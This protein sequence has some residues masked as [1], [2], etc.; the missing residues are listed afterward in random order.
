MTSLAGITVLITRSAHQ[1]G[2]LRKELELR[3]AH[4]LELPVIAICPPNSWQA[5]D[6]ALGAIA[7]YDW[8]IFSSTN[9]ATIVVERATTIGADLHELKARKTASIGRST[10]DR[11]VELG[12][13]IDFQPTDFVAESLLTELLQQADVEGKRILYPRNSSARSLITDTL[14]ENG[15]HVDAIDAYQTSL[16][17]PPEQTAR[18]LARILK[19]NAIDVI[20]LASAQSAKNL[21]TLFE[22]AEV[23]PGPN[24]LIATIG[25][26]TSNVA[27][28]LFGRVDV[29]AT[30]HT[31][32]GLVESLERRFL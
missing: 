21:A 3:G 28:R 17:D 8:I 12:F 31:A 20:T 30:P 29:E 16:P 1:A 10:S 5:L 11:L 25:P 24:C 23:A 7:S 4:A 19:D 26:V 14:R 32:H 27:R 6:T 18:E 2:E 13:N 15:A 22:M 9:T